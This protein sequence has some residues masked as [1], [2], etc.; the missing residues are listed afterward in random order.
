MKNL[1]TII[2][3]GLIISCNTFGA[4]DST[5]V[6]SKKYKRV[7]KVEKH[8]EKAP[9]QPLRTEVKQEQG[10]TPTQIDTF[11]DKD[12]DGINDMQD[13]GN[14]PLFRFLDE[15]ASSYVKEKPRQT[16]KVEAINQPPSTDSIVY[17]E[18]KV[19]AKELPPAQDKISV[20]KAIRTKRARK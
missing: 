9:A 17:G 7:L 19:N 6:V 10:N 8:I 1:I 18:Q 3:L 16:K 15:K 20:K 11:V 4:A 5:V 14:N 12:G 2:L 13:N